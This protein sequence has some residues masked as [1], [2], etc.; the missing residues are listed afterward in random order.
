MPEIWLSAK[1]LAP[2]VQANSSS[3]RS[4]GVLLTIN[5]VTKVFCSHSTSCA[6]K[7]SNT[8]YLH[9][10]KYNGSYK[11]ICSYLHLLMSNIN[12]G[13]FMV[14]TIIIEYVKIFASWMNNITP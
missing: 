9:M 5:L 1:S 10:Q 3:A 6:M 12:A 13:V 7:V 14:P 8:R 2:G 11:D 4:I